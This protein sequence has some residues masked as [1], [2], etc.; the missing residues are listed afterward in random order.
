[1]MQ[2]S[3]R[4][5]FLLTSEKIIHIL[6]FLYLC[7][8][9]GH[10][11]GVGFDAI[12]C[13]VTFVLLIG[14]DVFFS[15]KVILTKTLKWYLG[16]VGF[17]FISIIWTRDMGDFLSITI[18]NNF[19][20][21]IGVM[22][23][24]GNHFRTKEDYEFG[25]KCILWSIIYMSA[26][27]ILRTPLD[28]WGS[29]RVGSVMALNANDIG[30]RTSVGFALCLYFAKEKKSYY[31]FAIIMGAI[32]L[33][34]GSRKAFIF[35]L[36]EFSAFMLVKDH[37]WKRLLNICLIAAGCAALIYAVFNVPALYDVLGRRIERVLISSFG[38]NITGQYSMNVVD[39]SSEERALMR[40][41]AMQLFE[42]RPFFGH[43]GNGFVTE[44]RRINYGHVTYS[45]C[46]YT[47]LLSTLGIFGCVL[48]YWRPLASIIQG[49]KYYS[50]QKDILLWIALI[51]GSI[52]IVMDYY[53]VAYYSVFAL[54]VI[55]MD[56]G[57]ID[58]AWDSHPRIRE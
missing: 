52:Y 47:E 14:A 25:Y 8:L 46:N 38:I 43:G 35:V 12:F 9:S 16:F 29:E 3:K 39:A 17:Y 22:I 6:L 55:A 53:Y 50:C 19:I 2:Q 33:L 11:R 40:Q 10:K 18:W 4:S 20:Q 56:I 7:G 36:L 44:M 54:T 45:H 1:M 42:Q 51:V 48:Y 5:H 23:V 31:M 58:C 32:A 21:I 34:S 13:R 24:I 37:G 27:L 41:M 30:M 26:L 15:R 49:Y 57:Y 28:A